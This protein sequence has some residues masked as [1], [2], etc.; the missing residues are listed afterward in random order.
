MLA[1]GV[2]LAV[3]FEHAV[4]PFVFSVSSCALVGFV[5]QWVSPK[6]AIAARQ[7]SLI[8]PAAISRSSCATVIPR[9]LASFSS[10][11]FSAGEA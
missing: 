7:P 2:G 10:A 4:S 1:V 11:F 8:V 5:R 3:N 6:I 9:A